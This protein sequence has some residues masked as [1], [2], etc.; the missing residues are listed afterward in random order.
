MLTTGMME[1]GGGP[2]Q[3]L[4]DFEVWTMMANT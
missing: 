4:D 3:D 1:N 2:V